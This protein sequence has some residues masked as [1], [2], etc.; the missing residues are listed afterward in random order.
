MK[1]SPQAQNP[2]LCQKMQNDG[3]GHKPCHSD[4]PPTPKLR[5]TRGCCVYNIQAC[6][7]TWLHTDVHTHVCTCVRVCVCVCVRVHIAKGFLFRGNCVCVCVRACA[8]AC[9]V[10]VRAGGT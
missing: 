4:D 7:R 8:H 1:E 6:V 2:E 5:C 10:S 3:V 9:R